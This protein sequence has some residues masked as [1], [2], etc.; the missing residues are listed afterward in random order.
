MTENTPAVQLTLNAQFDVASC[1]ALFADQ[2]C[3][4]RAVAMIDAPTQIHAD[5][6]RLE[7]KYRE[8]TGEIYVM[9][10]SPHH[11][12]YYSP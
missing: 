9:R 11:R 8:R 2:P 1:H 3:N 5:L 6:L 7:L 12:W 4:A 10:D